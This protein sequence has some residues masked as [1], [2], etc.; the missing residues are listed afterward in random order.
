[1]QCPAESCQTNVKYP[2]QILPFV[3]L[4]IQHNLCRIPVLNYDERNYLGEM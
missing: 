1:M 3:T 4:K 2:T